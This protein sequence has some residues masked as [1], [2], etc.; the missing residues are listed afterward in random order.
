[1]VLTY[2][3]G[4]PAFILKG[5]YTN[6]YLEVVRKRGEEE[7]DQQSINDYLELIRK[8]G[9]EEGDLQSINDVDKTDKRLLPLTNSEKLYARALGM[10]VSD[11]NMD[12]SSYKSLVGAFLKGSD[13]KPK[14]LKRFW[15]EMN[16]IRDMRQMTMTD[17][18]L[19]NLTRY[20]LYQAEHAAASLEMDILIVLPRRRHVIGIR[21]SSLAENSD[22]LHYDLSLLCMA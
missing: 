18:E 10:E 5:Y 7:R 17:N 11:P 3:Q 9:E 1:V 13:E 2:S 14:N 12:L 19:T 21:L 6:K 20:L 4:E 15:D 8:R 16:K 22:V